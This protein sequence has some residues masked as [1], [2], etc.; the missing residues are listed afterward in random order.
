L[1]WIIDGFSQI[2]ITG[3]RNFRQEKWK[4]V[5]KEDWDK[6]DFFKLEGYRE[7]RKIVSAWV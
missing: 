5:G 7:R 1:G 2:D 6:G 3:N 4:K